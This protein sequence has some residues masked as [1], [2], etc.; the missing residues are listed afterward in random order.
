MVREEDSGSSSEEEREE[1]EPS[2]AV[3][4][5]QSLKEMFSAFLPLI[6]FFM[7]VPIVSELLGL[8]N[9]ALVFLNLFQNLTNV[10]NN[11]GPANPAS[12]SSDPSV[13]T[14][15]SETEEVADNGESNVLVQI[16]I[17]SLPNENRVLYSTLQHQILELIKLY[18]LFYIKD[19][20]LLKQIK[21]DQS[22]LKQ[23]IKLDR[24]CLDM[25]SEE[26]SIDAKIDLDTLLLRKQNVENTISV[27]IFSQRNNAK[28][29]IL[30]HLMRLD[31]NKLLLL[32]S[33]TRDIKLLKSA[34]KKILNNNLNRNLPLGHYN[35]GGGI[36]Y[37][38]FP[39][40]Q[41]ANQ[42]SSQSQLPSPQPD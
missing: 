38:L 33:K 4:Q 8:R 26:N 1:Q 39:V 17:P 21:T 29:S 40:Q 30:L 34:R 3:P 32:F 28:L 22:S 6:T 10:V 14:V 20:F 18:S 23:M 42:D 16:D 15:G 35:F 5:T 9:I 24:R 36:T 31:I 25:I 41:A 13:P 2:S 27:I 37:T 11:N 12:D 7:Y 19:K